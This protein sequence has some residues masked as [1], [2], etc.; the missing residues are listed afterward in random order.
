MPVLKNLLSIES[1]TDDEIKLIL[2]E[3]S[4]LIKY[5][6]KI[7]KLTGK[8]QLNFFVENSTR[9]AKS[10]EIAGQNLEMDVINLAPQTSSFSKG[11]TLLDTAKTL[12]SMQP[13]ILIL[14]HYESGAAEFLASRIDC[15]II[16]AGDGTH[17]HPTQA[18]LDCAT[19]IENK[20][21]ISGLNIT[22]CGDI[23]HSR[24][25][26]SNV[27]LFSRLGANLTLV[28]PKT[29]M[30]NFA[31]NSKVKISHD[32]DEA[33]KEADVIMMLRLQSER[34]SGNF[35]PSESEYYHFYGLTEARL[36]YADKNVKIMHPGP[37]N[38]GVEIESSVADAQ[39]SLIL[40]QVAMGVKMR[41]TLLSMLVHGNNWQSE[42]MNDKHNLY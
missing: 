7:A 40:S 21:A 32:F 13:D 24:V 11:E 33:L 31:P 20:G 17:E 37:M 35:I 19:I 38:R 39:Q 9:T 34:M 27:A 36:K 26:R 14:R 2:N 23:A 8:K 42:N 1:L 18:L 12:N 29:L 28:A 16:N 4:Y 30:P 41:M 5:P 25:A 10:F 6:N 22:I 15:P 3:N